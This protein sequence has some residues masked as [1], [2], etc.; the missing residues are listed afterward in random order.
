MSSIPNSNP[1]VPQSPATPATPP[2][3]S[4]TA[5]PPAQLL[6]PNAMT[7]ALK[8]VGTV[9]RILLL[10]SG[11]LICLCF[12]TPQFFVSMNVRDA[13]VPAEMRN[14]Y[15]HSWLLFGWSSWWGLLSFI[16]TFFTSLALIADVLLANIKG[17]RLM[18]RLIYPLVFALLTLTTGLGI[19]LGLFGV[20]LGVKRHFSAEWGPSLSDYNLFRIPIMSLPLL[21]LTVIGLV[22]SGWI[23]YKEMRG[24]SSTTVVSSSTTTSTGPSTTQTPAAG[25]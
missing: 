23:L 10:A 5:F 9:P 7:A 2:A 21:L 17:L 20:G 4:P 22:V 1:A 13:Q 8:R 18:L 25:I 16:F 3:N 14:Q 24:T 11:L 15:Y 19:L 6:S 12:F